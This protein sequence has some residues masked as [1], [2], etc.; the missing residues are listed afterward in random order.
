MMRML[1]APAVVGLAAAAF[2]PHTQM[3]GEYSFANPTKA[4][5]T[6]CHLPFVCTF[7]CDPTISRCRTSQVHRGDDYFEVYSPVYTSKY[8]QVNWNG[9]S[10]ALPQEIIKAWDGKTMAITGYEFDAVRSVGGVDAPC[11][12]NVTAH[13]TCNTTSVPAWEQYNHHYGNSVSGKGVAFI[14]VLPASIRVTL[15]RTARTEFSNTSASIRVPLCRTARTE[16]SNTSSTFL[17]IS[18]CT[19]SGPKICARVRS[20]HPHDGL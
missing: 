7:A 13:S 2:D 17:P 4:S 19:G 12:N 11:N 16:F 5:P 20:G 9:F 18:P 1:I 8:G 10:I 3:N 15:C 6:V 14:K